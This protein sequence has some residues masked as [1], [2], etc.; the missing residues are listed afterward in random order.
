[1]LKFAQMG[2]Y[3]PPTSKRPKIKGLWS[4]QITWIHSVVKKFLKT[5][6]GWAW[7]VYTKFVTSSAVN[8]T[9][10]VARI[11][12][13]INHTINS[14]YKHMLFFQG[15]HFWKKKQHPPGLSCEF[16]H[17]HDRKK[18]LGPEAHWDFEANSDM[19]LLK[20]QRL[21]ERNPANDCPPRTPSMP[22]QLKNQKP[23]ALLRLF[24]SICQFCTCEV[25]PSA[26]Y[27]VLCTFCQSFTRVRL[28][29]RWALVTVL[30]EGADGAK[31]KQYGQL[32][33]SSKLRATS[34]RW[35]WSEDQS[36]KLYY[37][38]QSKCSNP[39]EGL[40]EEFIENFYMKL[41]S[42]C[43]STPAEFQIVLFMALAAVLDVKHKSKWQQ[44]NSA[45]PCPCV[46]R[47]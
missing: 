6:S 36:I 34:P 12:P 21:W 28:C 4:I 23:W 11:P 31:A 15:L 14:N 35:L 30:L 5:G 13:S 37:H 45:A 38:V 41:K 9:S 33:E 25:S 39:V 47:Q 46:Y 43:H 32:I 8:W 20:A 3:P 1:M 26:S 7:W 29:S 42:V 19:R 40:R 17:W 2:Y 16:T 22:Q 24:V 44:R 10:P 18:T 27:H